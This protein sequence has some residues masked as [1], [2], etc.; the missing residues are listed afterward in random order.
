MTPL[1]KALLRLRISPDVITWAGTLGAVV[2][3]LVFFPQGM[4]WQ[5]TLTM[6]IFIFSDSIDGTMAR[7]SGRSS[8]WGAFLDATLDRVSDGAIFAGVALYYAGVGDSV[9]WCGLTLIALI[10]GQV[11]SYA[12]ARGEA[13]GFKVSGGLV[14]RADRLLILLIGTLGA[15]LGVGWMLKLAIGYLVVGGIV[16]VGERIWQVRSQTRHVRTPSVD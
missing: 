6:L 9:L 12:K 11:T 5:G 8:D 3:A 7:L 1:A 4:L 14:A 15:G 10:A 2:V 13:Q 16:T